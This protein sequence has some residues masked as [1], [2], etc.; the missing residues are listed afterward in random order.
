MYIK[1]AIGFLEKLNKSELLLLML[2][3]Q[4]ISGVGIII[5]FNFLP[6]LVGI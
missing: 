4:I 2:I 5:F 6:F 3:I 1:K